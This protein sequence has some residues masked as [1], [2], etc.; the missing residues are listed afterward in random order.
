M[1]LEKRTSIR[2]KPVKDRF[3]TVKHNEDHLARCKIEDISLSGSC[4]EILSGEINEN[5]KSKTLQILF[6]I[7]RQHPVQYEADIIREN[8]EKKW[9]AIKYKQQLS[10]H[11]LIQIRGVDDFS[12]DIAKLD[13][14]SVLAEALQIKTCSSNYFI[15]TIG[16]MV[17]LI[18]GIWALF[19]QNTISPSSCSGAMLGMFLL[20]CMSSFSN[21][22]KSRAI[23]KRE[24]FVAALDSYL[25]HGVAP[26]NYKGWE[27]LKYAYAECASKREAGICPR[28]LQKDSGDACKFIG[29]RKAQI[30][31]Y[32][33]IVP[34]ILDSFISLTS[35]FYSIIFVIITVL[36]AISIT[37][38]LSSPG[39]TIDADLTLV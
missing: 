32:K 31:E 19:I 30:N 11:E 36:S 9:Y 35:T 29:E 37:K 21:L 33:R 4:I 16:L 22:E 26:P 12:Y 1:S 2:F 20:F 25:V 5:L 6:N 7:N 23:Y 8:D 10:S 13:K 28:N 18:S 15:W 24:G 38:M 27:N 34:S 39:Y 14:S 3:A 17:P